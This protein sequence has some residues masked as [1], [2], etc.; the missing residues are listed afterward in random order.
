MFEKPFKKRKCTFGRLIRLGLS[1]TLFFAIPRSLCCYN[2][3]PK[4]VW[5]PLQGQ[6]PLNNE[7]L[8]LPTAVIL[9]LKPYFLGQLNARLLAQH[10]DDHNTSR[11]PLHS[12]LS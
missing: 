7:A 10:H 3:G 2:C 11:L 1:V 4:A 5:W 8:N 12:Q 9:H 6:C